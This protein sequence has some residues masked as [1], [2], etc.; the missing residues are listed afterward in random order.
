[1][2][3]ID[4]KMIFAPYDKDLFKK[5]HQGAIND[6]AWAPL[7]GRSF[8]M[9]A[10]AASDHKVLVWKLTV[11]DFFADVIND[12]L[13]QLRVDCIFEVGPKQMQVP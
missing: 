4:G 5:F 6:I 10:T 9:I 2:K 8:H 12:D 3:S 1:M 13:D 11:R 7:A